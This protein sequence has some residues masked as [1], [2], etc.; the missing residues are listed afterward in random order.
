[1]FNA[2]RW[3]LAAA[4][5][6]VAG[7]FVHS[8]FK[9]SAMIGRIFLSLVYRPDT[10]SSGPVRGERTVILDS[11]D[12][13]I[14]ALVLE[15]PGSRRAVVFCHESGS[16]KES[17]ERYAYFLPDLG[18]HLVSIDLGSP[19]TGQEDNALGQ[20]P[21][22]DGVQ[23]VL[24][25]VRWCRKAF[26]EDVE[27][28]LFG[29]SNGADIAFAASFE[30]PSVRAVVADGLFSMKEI[31]REYIRKW[32]PV[33]VRPNFFG[34]KYPEWIVRLFAELGFMRAT[35]MTGR[36]FVDVEPLLARPHVPLLM[37]HGEDDDYVSAHHQQ[38]LRSRDR[39]ARAQKH[40]VVREAGHNQSVLLARAVYEKEISEFLVRHTGRSE[41]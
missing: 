16:S 25:A 4:A 40:L 31:F 38:V 35:R 36:S 32:A 20:W 6:T 21:T 37:I 41:A 34:E 2:L 8:M 18:Y 24:T 39:Q 7:Y 12:H 30:D 13:E 11:S 3:A 15:H 19:D 17:W 10:A 28:V 27:I 9:Y 29:V 5:L 1:M 23:R 26:R 14:P 33:L 22:R